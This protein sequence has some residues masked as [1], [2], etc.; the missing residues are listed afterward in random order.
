MTIGHSLRTI[1]LL[2]VIAELAGGAGCDGSAP[3]EPEGAGTIAAYL[4]GAARAMALRN[5][6]K[7]ELGGGS[8]VGR[9]WFA[10]D[11]YGEIYEQPV[12]ADQSDRVVLFSVRGASELATKSELLP[13]ADESVDAYIARTRP[14]EVATHFDLSS[15]QPSE[16]GADV[17]LFQP[18]RQ[19]AS[20][21]GAGDVETRSS[22][23]FNEACPKASYDAQCARTFGYMGDR[24]VNRWNVFDRSAIAFS[25]KG[26]SAYGVACADRGTATLSFTRNGVGAMTFDL[27]EGFMGWAGVFSG[28]GQHEFCFTRF[29][30]CID[31]HY[32]VT[33]ER[34][35]Y[36]VALSSQNNAHFCGDIRTHDD[37]D[38]GDLSCQSVQRCP[39]VMLR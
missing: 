36:A 3:D 10:P 31:Y 25:A 7:M 9:V 13:Q 8:L 39:L 28:W 18:T 4:D 37:Y 26:T 5:Q 16:T 17:L 34:H 11:A 21:S 38:Q 15:G 23:L 2:A 29:I 22:A 32:R 30:G 19:A 14:G 35:N 33:F 20:S 24:S 27:S 6:S 1:G 12:N